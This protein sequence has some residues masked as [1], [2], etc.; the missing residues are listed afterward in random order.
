MML[1]VGKVHAPESITGDQVLF[2]VRSV[3]MRAVDDV[4]RTEN[5]GRIALIIEVK[6]IEKIAVLLKKCSPTIVGL[7]VL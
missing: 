2:L 6:I 1:T 5:H 4:R 3:A 7:P